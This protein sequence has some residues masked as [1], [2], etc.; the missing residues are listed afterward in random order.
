MMKSAAR[1]SITTRRIQELKKN[2]MLLLKMSD[3]SLNLFTCILFFA[4][5]FNDAGSP[6]IYIPSAIYPSTQECDC[7]I[8]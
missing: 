1:I 3:F 4:E 6:L 2:K 5:L 8:L 7:L